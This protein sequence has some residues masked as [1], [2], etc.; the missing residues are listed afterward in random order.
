[1][2]RDRARGWWLRAGGL[3]SEAAGTAGRPETVCVG[4]SSRVRPAHYSLYCI[5]PASCLWLSERLACPWLSAGSHIVRRDATRMHG[6]FLQVLAVELAADS[7]S[8]G[9]IRA[10]PERHTL[11]TERIMRRLI[12]HRSSTSHGCSSRCGRYELLR[13]DPIFM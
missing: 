1:M 4:Y 3:G 6:L 11:E 5:H 7:Q 13:S 10:S 2:V 12:M 8:R 9:A